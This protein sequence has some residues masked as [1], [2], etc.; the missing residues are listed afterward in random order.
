MN[1]SSGAT[2]SSAR[3]R[4]RRWARASASL[5]GVPSAVASSGGDAA[6]ATCQDG[7]AVYG[8]PQR[9]GRMGGVGD[10][11]TGS[12]VVVGRRGARS[13]PPRDVSAPGEPGVEALVQLGVVV[14][15]ELV[16]RGQRVR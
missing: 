9:S 4:A 11:E 10:G 8:L 12:S 6:A 1:R 13:T 3:R 2:R 5:S 7:R 15:P 14:D 16:G